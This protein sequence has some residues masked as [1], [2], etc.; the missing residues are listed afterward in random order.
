MRRAVDQIEFLKNRLATPP[1]INTVFPSAG[2][3][4]GPQMKRVAQLI[5]LRNDLSQKRQIFFC[6]IGGFDTHEAQANSHPRLITDVSK[7]IAALYNATVELGVADKVTIF[8]ASDF[9]RTLNVNGGAGTDHGWGGHHFGGGGAVNGGTLYGK[10]PIVAENSP[11]DVGEGRWLPTTSVDQYGA[12]LAKWFG[13]NPNNL[14]IVAPNLSN[15]NVADL[16][17]MR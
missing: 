11:D 17:F 5:A 8:T 16:G 13:V 1:P 7:L 3:Q 10:Y 12:T 14:P 2:S 9:G 6:G 4:L 15:F